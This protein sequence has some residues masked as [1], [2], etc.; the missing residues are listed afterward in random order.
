MIPPL[1]R[2]TWIFLGLGASQ[3]L[4]VPLPAQLPTDSAAVQPAA[5]AKA[6]PVPMPPALKSPV[7]FFRQLLAMNTGEREHFLA[8]RGEENRKRILA[9]VREYEALKPD[10]RELRLRVTELRWYLL[11]FMQTPATE[12]AAQLASVP[13]ADRQLVGDRLEQWDLLSPEEQKQVLQYETTMQYF[14]PRDSGAAPNTQ[15]LRSL[16]PVAREEAVRNLERWRTLPAGE[17]RQMYGRFQRFFELTDTEKEKTLRVLPVVERQ[18]MEKTLQTFEHLPPIR[19][20]QCLQAFGKFASMTDEERREF[21]NNAERWKEMSPAERRAWRNLV[22]R[23]PPLP[24]GAS[25]PPMPP[26]PPPPRPPG[27]PLLTNSSN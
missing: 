13:E 3:W 22:D 9:K 17:R 8:D 6:I 12:R 16:P 4:C 24:P 21:V 19:R 23:L 1:R 14:V 20:E 18:Q 27:L 2:A 10:E 11:R 5:V 25:L 26:M 15:A 7:D